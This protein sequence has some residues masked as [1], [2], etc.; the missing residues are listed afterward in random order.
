M[1]CA[2]SRGI[3]LG[4]EGESRATWLLQNRRDTPSVLEGS[5]D[6]IRRPGGALLRGGWGEMERERMVIYRRR[7]GKDLRAR[8]LELKRK[9]IT[10]PKISS[11]L[12]RGRRR[13]WQVGPTCQRAEE[14]E[15]VPLWV[16]LGGPWAVS[17]SGPK[18]FPAD[19]L[20]IFFLLFLFSFYDLYFFIRIFKIAPIQIK[21]IPN[22]F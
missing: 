8:S 16:S 2:R 12:P 18:G 15:R 21:P 4:P 1:R 10:R 14:R 7:R 22:I 11:W 9:E 17:I 6:E 3:E 13:C 20:L 19:L 5:G